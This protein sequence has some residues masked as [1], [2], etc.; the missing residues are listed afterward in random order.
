MYIMNEEELRLHL[1]TMTDKEISLA[2]EYMV[3]LNK[4]QAA[5]RSLYRPTTYESAASIASEI[6]KVPRVAK[7]VN[8]LKAIRAEQTGVTAQMV[9]RQLAKIAFTEIGDLVE[10]DDNGNMRIKSFDEMP[11]TAPIGEITV[12]GV[13][14]PHGEEIARITK[15]KLQS[16]LKA[17]ELLGKHTAIF[18]ENINLMSGGKPI[19]APKVTN[20]III[21]HRSRGTTLEP[22]T[23]EE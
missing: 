6:L 15:M 3:D 20:N 5:Y 16:Q 18:T 21:N 7:F 12:E 2:R 22:K 14:G 8:H 19:E 11:T 9:I 4:T 23:E 17:L 10:Y 13:K 1:D